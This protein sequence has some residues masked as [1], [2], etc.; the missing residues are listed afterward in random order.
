MGIV[1][2]FDNTTIAQ[3]TTEQFANARY[4]V[5]DWSEHTTDIDEDC[6]LLVQTRKLRTQQPAQMYDDIAASDDIDHSRVSRSWRADV[7]QRPGCVNDAIRFVVR[8]LEDCDQL[9]AVSYTHLTLPT[10]LRV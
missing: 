2:S 4:L 5:D 8:P 3:P 10:I 1:R 9:I 6:A 7:R